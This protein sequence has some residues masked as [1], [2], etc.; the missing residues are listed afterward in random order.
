MYE[1]NTWVGITLSL[2]GSIVVAPGALGEIRKRARHRAHQV[3]GQLARFLPFLRRNATVRAVTATGSFGW[4][5]HAT[6]TASGWARSS[7]TP[8]EQL[9]KIWEQVGRLHEAIAALATR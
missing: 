4:A 6:V 5:G 2:L 7:G 8:E 3:R 9:D 1:I